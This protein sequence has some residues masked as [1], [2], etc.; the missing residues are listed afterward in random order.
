MQ[1]FVGTIVSKSMKNTV[2]VSVP[3][4]VRHPKYHKILKRTTN[5]LAHTDKEDLKVGQEVTI[6]KTRPYSKNTHFKVVE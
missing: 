2:K 1:T 5:L 6:V 3:Y 4:T